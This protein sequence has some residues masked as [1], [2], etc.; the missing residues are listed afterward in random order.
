MFDFRQSRLSLRKK[1]E[2]RT[3]QTN[4]PFTTYFH[5]KIILAHQVPI[6]DDEVVDYIVD[7]IPDHSLRDQACIMQFKSQSELLEAFKRL[8]LR[9]EKCSDHESEKLVG[10]GKQKGRTLSAK[11]NL[12]PKGNLTSSTGDPSSP[13]RIVKCYNCQEVG[14]LA[15]AC[16]HPKKGTSKGRVEDA[17]QPATC[18]KTALKKSR[19]PS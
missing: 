16:S 1:F 8:T 2:E 15:S 14:H 9:S 11:E 18:R 3:W 19:N 5:D 10:L 12:T 4:E 13:R 7:G 6:A 17:V